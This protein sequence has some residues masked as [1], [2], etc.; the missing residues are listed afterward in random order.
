MIDVKIP[1]V[2]DKVVARKL[3]G[4][5]TENSLSTLPL[6]FGQSAS[7]LLHQISNDLSGEN[8]QQTYSLNH[9]KMD[10]T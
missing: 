3:L 10:E 7:N 5:L 1:E 4:N 6:K 9:L 8:S 2:A